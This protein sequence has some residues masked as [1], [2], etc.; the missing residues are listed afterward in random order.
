MRIT[1]TTRV[2]QDYRTVYA[3]FDQDLFV[4]LKPPLLPLELKRFDGSKTGDE[5]HIRLGKWHLAQDWN[6]KIVEDNIGE[7][8]AY[9]IDE[10]IKLPFFLKSWRHHHRI[11]RTDSGSLIIDDITYT[12]PTWLTDYLLYPLMWLQFAARKPVYR[13]YFANHSM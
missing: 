1:L 2:D 13:K 10:G 4:A 6:A 5:V 9:F 12:T 3:R 11:V 8:E 7:D